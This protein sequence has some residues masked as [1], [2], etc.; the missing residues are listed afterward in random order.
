M[1]Q[2]YA[3]IAHAPQPRHPPPPGPLLDNDRRKIELANA[4]FLACPARHIYYGDEIGMGENIHLFDR[5][6]VRTPMQWT[7]QP[8]AVF[9]K[10]PVSLLGARA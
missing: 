2:L 6:G 10:P 4:F 5:N 7:A 8:G 9:R 3:R 1:W